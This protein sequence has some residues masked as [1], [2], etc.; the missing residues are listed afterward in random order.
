MSKILGNLGFF[1]LFCIFFCCNTHFFRYIC[2]KKVSPRPDFPNMPR[3]ICNLLILISFLHFW[4]PHVLMDR[5]AHPEGPPPNPF[6][7]QRMEF[8]PSLAVQRRPAPLPRWWWRCWRRWA[9]WPRRWGPRCCASSP[10]SPPS[11]STP[12][13]TARRPPSVRQPSGAS[14]GQ[15]T[16]P[17]PF[18]YF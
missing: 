16:P 17:C 11:S 1:S 14:A 4:N 13:T 8:P 3:R 7:L 12:S 15:A 2:L 18:L 9:T 5:V 6:A 10:P